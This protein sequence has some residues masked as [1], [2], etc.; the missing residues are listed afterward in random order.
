MLDRIRR[1]LQRWLNVP[2][3]AAIDLP[4]LRDRMDSLERLVMSH[5]QQPDKETDLSPSA[6][7]SRL[8]T[9]PDVH[10]GAQ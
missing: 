10:L 1:R 6:V 3:P 8:E 7:L 9:Q 2:S 4:V 5:L